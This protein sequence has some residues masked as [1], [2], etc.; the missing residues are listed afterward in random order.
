M[1]RAQ[2][3]LVPGIADL[4]FAGLLVTRLQPTL[5]HDGDTGW[6]LWAG[7]A[8]LE[9]GPGSIPDV[10]SFTRAGVPFANVEWLGEALLSLLWRH[11]GYTGVALVCSVVFAATFAWLYRILVGETRNPPV[12]LLVTALAAQVTL[13]QF[14]ARP[15]ILSFPLF[16][17]VVTLLRRRAG[18]GWALAGVPLL[19]ALWANVHPSAYLAP[20]LALWFWLHDPRSFRRA[21]TAL[22]AG[23]ALGA[24]P[25]GFH[26]IGE[27]L[28]TNRPYM[29]LVQEWG[30]PRFSEFRFVPL[31]AFLVLALAAR[32]GAPARSRG[33]LVWG[34][35]WMAAAL[36]ST[37]FA[38]YAVLAWAPSLAADLARGSFFRWPGRPGRA[39][40]ELV[41]GLAP[42][43]AILRPRFWPVLLGGAA[44]VL[45]PA[46]GSVF[47]RVAVGFPADRFPRAALDHAEAAGLGPRVFNYYG[48]GGMIAWEGERRWQVFI[49]GRAG[50]F[51]RDLLADYLGVMGVDPDWEAILA[52][53]RPDWVL[54]PRDASLVAAA[55]ATGRWR[56]EYE[57]AVASVLVPAE[58]GA[59][60]AGTPEAGEAASPRAR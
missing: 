6:H 48:W 29:P 27:M 16:L 47:P 58:P 40:K 33:D 51:G 21:L 22:L 55:V 35:G 28:V 56:L 25:W 59:D 23:A 43:E 8:V 36:V 46:L 38:P 11:A 17:G 54:V 24:T 41:A 39:W 20:A 26:W 15:L 30:S 5:F 57:D 60:S 31:L 34:L 42:M 44:L 13:L 7:G 9:R 4:L 14:L 53:H 1:N 52:G 37:R 32:R 10:L 45:A 18:T 2:R 50:F 19:T 49:D 3:L 12:S